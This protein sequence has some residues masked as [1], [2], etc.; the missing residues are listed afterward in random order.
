MAEGMEQAAQAFDTAI[1][2]EASKAPPTRRK[3]PDPEVKPTERLFD[4]N[5]EVDDESPPAGGGDEIP[6]PEAAIYEDEKEARRR[7]RKDNGKS[8]DDGDDERPD[9]GAE[10][11]EGDQA[12]DGAGD[13]EFLS[14]EVQVVVDGEERTVKMKEALEGYVRTETFHKRLNEIDEAKKIVQRAAADAVQNYEYTMNLGKEMEELMNSIVPKEP[15]W[16][17]EFAKNPARAR[18]LQKYYE[19]VRTFKNSM[20]AKLDEATKKQRESNNVQ[21]A[22]F[23]EA[24]A[25]RFDQKNAKHWA[26]DPKRRGKDIDAMRRTALAEGFSEDEIGQVYDSRMLQVLLKASKYDRMMAAR[27]KPVQQ[28]RSKPVAPGAGSA[29]SRTAQRGISTA[30]KRL[31]QSGSIEDAALVFDEILKRG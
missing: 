10:E 4:R 14:Q 26:A 23:A 20:Q 12:G 5:V 19:Q 17:E 25:R 7:A 1:S 6:D 8:Q 28:S 27:P 30:M 16:D 11:D 31:N 9:D 29:R 24:E 15:N 21:L 3:D 22:T 13:D 2:G 18:E